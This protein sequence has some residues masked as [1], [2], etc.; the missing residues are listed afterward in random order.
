MKGQPGVRIVMR[1]TKQSSTKIENRE[2]KNT[3][4]ELQTEK[5][6]KEDS[7]TH[8]LIKSAQRRR[9]KPASDHSHSPIFIVVIVALTSI[10]N[11]QAGASNECSYGHGSAALV[12][13]I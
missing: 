4:T 9:C 10:P 11:M 6:K 8:R 12:G 5:Q 7:S 3:R 13:I 1:K 2:R